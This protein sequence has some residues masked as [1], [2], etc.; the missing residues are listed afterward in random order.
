MKNI[1]LFVLTIFMFSCM[2]KTAQNG[3]T[4]MRVEIQK[5]LDNYETGQVKY[6]FSRRKNTNNIKSFYNVDFYGLKELSKIKE[7]ISKL[8][9]VA[10]DGKNI[11]I[12]IKFYEKEIVKNGIRQK[13]K[14]I[15][16]EEIV[17]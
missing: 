7:I 13:E 4:N 9:N 16:R 15:Q 11:S 8:D 3:D 17:Y 10:R 6:Y 12:D 14:V 5:I 1:L 2:S